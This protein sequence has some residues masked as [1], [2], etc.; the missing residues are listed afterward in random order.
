MRDSLY[1]P[2]QGCSAPWRA[3]PTQRA[4]VR[5]GGL[6]RRCT[7]LTRGPSGNMYVSLDPL[8]DAI[9]PTERDT[10]AQ[11]VWVTPDCLIDEWEE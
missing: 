3:P 4:F 2:C 8:D 7:I 5:H 11:G 1:R 10:R 9:A 6:Q